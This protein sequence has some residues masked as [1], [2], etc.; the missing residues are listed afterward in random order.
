MAF[1][2]FRDRLKERAPE[3]VAADTTPKPVV[4]I[5]DDDEMVGESLEIALQKEFEVRY[6]SESDK[7]L[8]AVSK[9][10]DVVVLDIKMPG[11]D[12]FQVYGEI[13]SRFPQMPII[14]YSAYQDMLERIEIR[15]QYKPFGHFDKNGKIED[16]FACIKQGI[17]L[18]GSLKSLE[19]ARK[20]LQKE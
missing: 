20:R 5:I 11:K 12:G 4:M 2:N 1:N 8:K 19:K 18:R 17:K 15:R 13:K 7:G 6:F 9:E 3:A 14:F 16:L 10:V